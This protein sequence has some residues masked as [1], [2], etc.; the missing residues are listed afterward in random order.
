MVHFIAGAWLEV[1]LYH[2]SLCD[3]PVPKC[4]LIRDTLFLV[5]R[6]S[7][8]AR[9]F[10]EITLPFSFYVLLKWD[11]EGGVARGM[12]LALWQR[13][14][15]NVFTNT[16]MVQSVSIG[17]HLPCQK[18]KRSSLDRVRVSSLLQHGALCMKDSLPSHLA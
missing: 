2:A 13:S 4:Y 6:F 12:T 1:G 9:Y 18:R 5:V 3:L 15:D 17:F 8:L 11:E 14:A 16:A 10:F 7:S